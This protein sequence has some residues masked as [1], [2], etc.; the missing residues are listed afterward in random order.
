MQPDVL[1]NVHPVVRRQPAGITITEYNVAIFRRCCHCFIVS[2][3]QVLLAG[4]IEYAGVYYHKLKTASA[5]ENIG[6]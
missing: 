5:R 6:G 1:S 2:T 4:K 3:S